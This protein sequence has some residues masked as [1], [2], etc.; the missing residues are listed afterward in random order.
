MSE[1]TARTFGL[2]LGLLGISMIIIAIVGYIGAPEYHKQEFIVRS[3]IFGAVGFILFSIGFYYYITYKDEENEE[4]EETPDVDGNAVQMMA[5]DQKLLS[6]KT[7]EK[8]KHI[9]VN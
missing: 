1:R 7:S 4:N 9:K 8:V 3:L 2:I 6:R 5:K